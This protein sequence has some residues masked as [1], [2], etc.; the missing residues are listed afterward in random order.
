VLTKY[1]E[2]QVALMLALVG[3]DKAFESVHLTQAPTLTV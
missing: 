2:M 1:P 3:Q